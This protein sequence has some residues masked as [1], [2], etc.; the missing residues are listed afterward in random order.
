[1]LELN[2]PDFPT[3]NTED[4]KKWTGLSACDLK[5]SKMNMFPVSAV[6][7]TGQTTLRFNIL[8]IL[9]MTFVEQLYNSACSETS[10]CFLKKKL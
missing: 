4:S 6:Y 10:L 3:T 9:Q 1:M 7:P 2:A 5:L 8:K